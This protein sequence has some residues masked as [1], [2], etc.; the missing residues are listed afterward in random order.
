MGC[1]PR[2]WYYEVQLKT[3]DLWN[4]FKGAKLS[5]FWLFSKVSLRSG[6]TSIVPDW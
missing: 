4:A 5:S 6:G 2:K 1:E 3:P